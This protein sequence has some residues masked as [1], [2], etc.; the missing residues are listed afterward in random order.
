MGF[1]DDIAGLVG[2][3]VKVAAAP[4]QVVASVARAVTKPIAEV[5]EVIV[6]EVKDLTGND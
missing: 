3:V 2:D 5:A 6:E 1:F 4:V